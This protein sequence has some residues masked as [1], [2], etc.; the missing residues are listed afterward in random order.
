MID[1]ILSILKCPFCGTAFKNVKILRKKPS[2]EGIYGI[3]KCNC[4][5][6]PIVEDIFYLKKDDLLSNR[7]IV[8]NIKKQKKDKAVWNSLAF[9]S[10]RH[11]IL[12]FT[13][14][15]LQKYLNI[16]LD[17]KFVLRL[18]SIIGPSR[19]WFKYLSNRESL[20]DPQHSLD[21]ME[22][23]T[24][25]K[26]GVIIDVGYGLGDFQRMLAKNKI[27]FNRY[28]G[29]DKNFFSLLTSQI[30]HKPKD[31]ILVCCDVNFGL[32]IKSKEADFVLLI[33]SPKLTSQQT[34]I[35]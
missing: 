27:Y 7:K 10:K 32:P 15:V 18:F 23:S 20:G 30:F 8:E 2:K 6:F 5:E 25:A 26:P 14:F 13:I 12:I 1:K 35:A 28:I 9:T 16:I 19:S 21:V 29:I 33:G 34:K 11:K 22:K 3:I 24:P 17:Y 4:D 31:A